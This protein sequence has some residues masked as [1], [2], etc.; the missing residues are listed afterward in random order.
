MSSLEGC[1]PLVRGLQDNFLSIDFDIGNGYGL[2]LEKGLGVY[3]VRSYEGKDW[4]KWNA[5]WW[6]GEKKLE[7]DLEIVGPFSY[8]HFVSIGEN[9][10]IFEL[11][12]S[13][14]SY[15]I[16]M[17]F[18]EE[19]LDPGL[20]IIF[21]YKKYMDCKYSRDSNPNNFDKFIIKTC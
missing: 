20:A 17:T 10:L 13:Y 11:G 18:Y 7:N 21:H 12:L 1:T 4:K 14:E 9:K 15:E 3:D 19:G 2:V 8:I 5:T 6:I 16:E